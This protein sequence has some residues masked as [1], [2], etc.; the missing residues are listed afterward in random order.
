MLK[1]GNLFAHLLDPSEEEKF[2]PIGGGG[3]VLIE[4]IT[5]KGQTTPEGEEY[6]QEQTEWV[7]LLQGVARIK[8]AG[9]PEEITLHAGDYVE[10]PPR[11]RHSVT[12]TSSS[13]VAIWLAVHYR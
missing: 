2:E 11:A 1:R 4:R 6:D 13:P 9:E 3:S 7:A 5:S 12:Y 8:V 10:L